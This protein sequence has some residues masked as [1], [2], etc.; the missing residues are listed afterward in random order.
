MKKTAK[1][2]V[3]F[4]LMLMMASSLMYQPLMETV[5]YA[6]DSASEE[7]S[8]EE[9]ASDVTD[10]IDAVLSEDEEENIETATEADEVSVVSDFEEDGTE[11]VSEESEAAE[12]LGDASDDDTSEA[13]ESI[14]QISSEDE[15]QV[16]ETEEKSSD[17]AAVTDET[18]EE[19]DN[20][21]DGKDVSLLEDEENNQLISLSSIT[22]NKAYITLYDQDGKVIDTTNPKRNR[23]KTYTPDESKDEGGSAYVET[24]LGEGD[25]VTVLLEMEDISDYDGTSAGVQENTWYY[26]E[27]PS[28]LVP[29]SDIL[30]PEEPIVLFNYGKVEADG[31]IYTTENGYQLR[32]QFYKVTDQIGVSGSYQWDSTVAANLDPL[33]WQ[34]MEFIPGGEVSFKTK[35]AEEEPGDYELTSSVTGPFDFDGGSGY[36]YYLWQIDLVDNGETKVIPYTY[37][38]VDSIEN[39]YI[40]ADALSGSG[41]TTYKLSDYFDV[42]VTYA[43]SKTETKLSSW[44]MGSNAFYYYDGSFDGTGLVQ[45]DWSYDSSLYTSDKT[46]GSYDYIKAFKVGLAGY[47]ANS[48]AGKDNSK[49]QNIEKISVRFKTLI[50]NN[51][52]K[53]S[54][55]TSISASIDIPDAGELTTSTGTGTSYNCAH[56]ENFK[57]TNPGNNST[58]DSY[59]IDKSTNAVQ[60]GGVPN[61]L[62]VTGDVI[63]DKSS[64]YWH[65]K[66]TP[67]TKSYGDNQSGL[68]YAIRNYSFNKRGGG[69]VDTTKNSTPTDSDKGSFNK[70]MIGSTDASTLA[71]Y[72]YA[73]RENIVNWIVN[74][75]N[76]PVTAYQIEQALK[77]KPANRNFAVF[78]TRSNEGSTDI[79]GNKIKKIIILDSENGCDMVSSYSSGNEPYLLKSPTS[80]VPATWDVYAFGVGDDT[81]ASFDFDEHLV[82]LYNGREDGVADIPSWSVSNYISTGQYSTGSGTGGPLSHTVEVVPTWIDEDTIMWEATLD[83]S[84]FESYSFSSSGTANYYV[85]FSDGVS[86]T[87][88][89]ITYDG[90]TF[91][92]GLFYVKNSS[93]G[94]TVLNQLSTY[95]NS[96]TVNVAGSTYDGPRMT[97]SNWSSSACSN[98]KTN[99]YRAQNGTYSITNN[100]VDDQITFRYFTKV[101]ASAITGSAQEFSSQLEIDLNAQRVGKSSRGNNMSPNYSYKFISPVATATIPTLYKSLVKDESQANDSETGLAIETYKIT[102]SFRNSSSGPKTGEA[103]NGFRGYLSITDDMKSCKV[104]DVETSSIGKNAKVTALSII[105]PNSGSTVYELTEADITELNANGSITRTGAKLNNGATQIKVS[106]N[107]AKSVDEYNMYNGIK[108]EVGNVF[109]P[110]SLNIIYSVAVDEAEVAAAEKIAPTDSFKMSLKN[111]ARVR[112]ADPDAK[113]TPVYASNERIIAAALA[114]S[115]KAGNK[116]GGTSYKYTLRSNELHD[117]SLTAQIGYRAVESVTVEDFIQQVDNVNQD[118]ECTNSYKYDEHPDASKLVADHLSVKELK[119]TEVLVGDADKEETVYEDGKAASGWNVVFNTNKDGEIFNI[120]ISKTDGTKIS[121][122]T[123]FTFTYDAELDIR[124]DFRSSKYYDGAAIYATNGGRAEIA[125]KEDTP[126]TASLMEFDDIDT[127]SGTYEPYVN[128]AD[129]TLVTYASA[130]NEYLTDVEAQKGS[131]GSWTTLA[132]Q[133]YDDD[134]N[135]VDDAGIDYYIA[136]Y[137]GTY[138]KNEYPENP[139]MTDTFSYVYEFG[140]NGTDADVH[141]DAETI[142][143]EQKAALKDIADTYNYVANKHTAIQNL[144]VF[145]TEH[146]TYN[147]PDS[148]EYDEWAAKYMIYEAD[149]VIPASVPSG[150]GTSDTYT[151]TGTDG[152]SITYSYTRDEGSQAG[153]L[154]VKLNKDNIDYDCYVAATYE[155]ITYWDDVENDPLY[156]AVRQRYADLLSGID[157][158]I[159]LKQNNELVIPG[160]KTE[161]TEE[162]GTHV[163]VPVMEF[164]KTAENV[165]NDTGCADWKLEGSIPTLIASNVKFHDAVT[166]DDEIAAKY[167]TI[168]NVRLHQVEMLSTK[169]ENLLKDFQM[170]ILLSQ[171][172]TIR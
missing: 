73:T 2:I 171:L 67:E 138:G 109:G 95:S 96:S 32:L 141:Y 77:D 169:M 46:I 101:D 36:D 74:N 103:L 57:T 79:N 157:Y 50:V 86:V 112:N 165:N 93:G 114:L 132:K 60:Y 78:Y 84:L 87:N 128:T 116:A 53:T 120:T 82:S 3:S 30:D 135:L 42:Y 98:S 137:T 162:T 91:V 66:Y 24:K 1:K 129:G 58:I 76:D 158:H 51:V 155:I 115:K 80:N 35:P 170:I 104:N 64:D 153:E 99:V 111:S 75:W 47:K 61:Y 5:V 124:K 118:G 150:K 142:T 70:L 136:A 126:S 168:E 40:I 22:N 15:S 62:N 172:I 8:I 145:Y 71:F 92:T 25:G 108:V 44:Q 125:Y 167:T 14:E 122:D 4:F 34:K 105:N 38:N 19:K 39:T 164:A 106:Y 161:V 20:S 12:T 144:K 154:V 139:V 10:A 83:A 90:T 6:D 72:N 16:A 41:S 133:F 81:T 123:I 117:Y 33:T 94:Y 52:G 48:G 54:E 149:G 85:G 152:T 29:V 7:A 18:A 88:G 113:S 121:P 11:E 63:K 166:I 119:I 17:D 13:E 102:A 37:L 27:L 160:D 31:G 23:D 131:T 21:D 55:S 159:L 151:V 45:I 110:A 89:E 163:Q 100:I 107:N 9:S 143:D 140:E 127:N 69:L 134:I 49:G 146:T 130:A 68:Y 156:V 65:I 148:E 147:F 26:V 97:R 59:T 43:G 56:V 28:Q